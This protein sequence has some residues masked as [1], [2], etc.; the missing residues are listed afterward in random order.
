MVELP[1]V[2]FGIVDSCHSSLPI[3]TLIYIIL[4]FESLSLITAHMKLLINLTFQDYIQCLILRCDIG[5]SLA[6]QTNNNIRMFEVWKRKE[7]KKIW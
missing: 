4:L 7:S 6:E 1:I 5:H 2:V 3:P